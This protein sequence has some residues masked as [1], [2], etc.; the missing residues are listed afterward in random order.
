[1]INCS[2][3]SHTALQGE[4]EMVSRRFIALVAAF[5]LALVGSTAAFAQ[6]APQQDSKKRS[7]Q[8]Q[9]EIEQM[10]KLVDSVA[11]G[12]PGPSDVQLTLTPFFLKSQEQRTFVPFALSVA[13]AP[14]ADAVLYVRVVNPQA[15]VADPKE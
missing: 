13:N 2:H 3:L 10:V 8:E 15:A 12:Q 4:F 9:Q 7:K 1:M 6:Q 11:A 5:A 14:A